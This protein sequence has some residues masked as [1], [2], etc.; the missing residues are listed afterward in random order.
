[1][2]W[3]P[4]IMQNLKSQKRLFLTILL[5]KLCYGVFLHKQGTT[6][7][8]QKNALEFSMATHSLPIFL[9]A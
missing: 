6:L 4:N 7:N 2:V 1:M 9:I 8:K 3:A 5:C